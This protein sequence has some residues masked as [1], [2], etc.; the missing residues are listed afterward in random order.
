MHRQAGLTRGMK[1]VAGGEPVVERSDNS[2]RNPYRGSGQPSLLFA[3]YFP[4]QLF[5]FVFRFRDTSL[6]AGI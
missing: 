4:L 1:L 3:R 5:L 2:D 6:T